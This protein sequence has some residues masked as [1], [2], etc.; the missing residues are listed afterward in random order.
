M[1]LGVVGRGWS[2]TLE[3]VGFCFFELGGCFVSPGGTCAASTRSQTQ[4]P[5]P[6]LV[7][8]ELLS[9]ARRGQLVTK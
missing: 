7:L 1:T 9:G 4:T 8:D 6:L 2:E 5:L 3:Q